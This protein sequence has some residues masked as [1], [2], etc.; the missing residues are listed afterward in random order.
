[1]GT[2]EQFF[3]AIESDNQGEAIDI[4]N[5]LSDTD[6]ILENWHGNTPLLEAI[7]YGRNDIVKILIE[8]LSYEN[9]IITDLFGNTPLHM[10]A[11]YGQNNILKTLVERSQSQT[12]QSEIAEERLSD[13]DL[14]K[15]NWNGNTPLHIA[16]NAGNT[17]IV[18][19]LL[20]KLKPE[21][22]FI[23]NRKGETP[24]DRAKN[25][26]IKSLLTPFT[27]SSIC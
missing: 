2:I 3:R 22:R 24:L 6:L 9:I 19:T 14:I 1:M 5:E 23:E 26:E 18:K 25:D 27:K 11:M 4:I 17:D 21:N 13:D 10:A 16:A 12:L 20:D 7:V 8:R 15:R